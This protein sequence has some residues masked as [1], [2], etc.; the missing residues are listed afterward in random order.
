MLTD[1]NFE[2]GI[3]EAAEKHAAKSAGKSY[4][5]RN[6]IDSILNTQTVGTG[7]PNLKGAGHADEIC[8][9]FR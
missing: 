1:L 7:A 4:F 8:Y 3:N 6:S 9:I 5:Y 2:Y